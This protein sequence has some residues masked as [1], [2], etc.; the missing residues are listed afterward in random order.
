MNHHTTRPSWGRL[1]LALLAASGVAV[2]V[3]LL[4]ATAALSRGFTDPGAVFA[5]AFAPIG[6]PI[7]AVFALPLAIAVRTGLLPAKPLW[8]AAGG[9]A[10][11]LAY[12]FAG[13]WAA[14]HHPGELL[15]LLVYPASSALLALHGPHRLEMTPNETFDFWLFRAF[16]VG[17]PLGG[18]LGGLT[19]GRIARSS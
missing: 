11:A 18:L 8:M 3:P 1:L 7:A 13:G 12:L 16:L 19:L 10:T 2:V 5:M 9:L 17:I 14:R 6:I 15:E 4:L